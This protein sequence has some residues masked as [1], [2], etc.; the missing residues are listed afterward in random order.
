MS[1]RKQFS[2]KRKRTDIKKFSI[3]RNRMGMVCVQRTS[4]TITF[5][6]VRQGERIVIR[7]LKK[8]IGKGGVEM[9]V[10]K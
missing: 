9:L 7:P 8:V 4:K 3:H 2:S 1:R 10:E 5:Q 6:T